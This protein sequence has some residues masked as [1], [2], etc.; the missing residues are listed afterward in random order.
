MKHRTGREM[1]F[2][3]VAHTLRTRQDRSDRRANA[4]KVAGDKARPLLLPMLQEV[5]ESEDG[6]SAS[7][8]D[9][10]SGTDG[11][12]NEKS[13]KQAG[14]MQEGETEVTDADGGGGTERVEKEK[15]VEEDRGGKAASSSS[16]SME[17]DEE[18][19]SEL[20]KR[21][22]KRSTPAQISNVSTKSKETQQE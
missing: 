19:E 7:L 2:D 18:G 1:S 3:E 9:S 12:E 21:K 5:S 8:R 4:R 20:Q 16:G 6:G 15:E 13:E 10:S 14:E 17:V 22:R 11:D